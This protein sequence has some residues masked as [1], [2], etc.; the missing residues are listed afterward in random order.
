MVEALMRRHLPLPEPVTSSTTQASS[1]SP[2]RRSRAHNNVVLPKP[3]TLCTPHRSR[4]HDADDP[5]R[6]QAHSVVVLPEPATSRARDVVDLVPS[7]SL[8]RRRPPQAR[9]ATMY[10]FLCHFGPINL[11]FDMLHCHVALICYIAFILLH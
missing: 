1:P 10:I 9:K 7:L 2:R 8:Q 4:A 11:D 6:T 3:V 5:R